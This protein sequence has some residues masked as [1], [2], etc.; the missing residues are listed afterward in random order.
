MLTHLM[1]LHHIADI[2][3]DFLILFQVWEAIHLQVIIYT[4]LKIRSAG[5]SVV[6][7]VTWEVRDGI[8]LEVLPPMQLKR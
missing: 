6:P 8:R 7:V 3:R 2:P 1:L 5:D 4:D